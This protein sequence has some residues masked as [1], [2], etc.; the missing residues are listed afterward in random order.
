[1]RELNRLLRHIIAPL[2]ALAV[3][4]G[5]LPEEVQHDV[6]EALVLVLGLLLPLLWSWARERW[7]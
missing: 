4:E 3:A 6:T 5:W 1:M 2:A 7:G